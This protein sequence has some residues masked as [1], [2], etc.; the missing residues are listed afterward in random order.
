MDNLKSAVIRMLRRAADDLDAGTCIISDGEAIDIISALTHRA[1]S[2]ESACSHLNVSRSKFDDL[3]RGGK[4]P[5]GR[6]R[7][8]FKELCWY[9]DEINRA[10]DENK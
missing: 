10:I 7:R 2:K 9:E 5:R 3:V 6:K 1:I 8:G 4:L